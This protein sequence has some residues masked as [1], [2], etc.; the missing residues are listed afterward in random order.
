MSKQVTFIFRCILIAVFVLSGP[1]LAEEADGHDHDHD[2]DHHHDHGHAQAY[3]G[4]TAYYLAEHGD[5]D[6]GF[7]DGQLHLRIHLHAGT[8]VDGEP[9]AKETVF[10]PG[11]LIVVATEEAEIPR[12][13]GELWE[14]TG[15]EPNDAL[16]VLPQIGREHVPAFG[17]ATEEIDPGFFVDD[18]VVLSL[19]YLNGPGDFSL[20]QSDA[21]GIPTFLFSSHANL[22]AAGV[23]VGRHAHYNWAFTAPGDYTLVFEAT[24]QLVAGG[25]VSALSVYTFKVTEGPLCLAPLPGDVNG[26]CVVD[27]Y[28]LEIVQA[29]LGK[30]APRW[31]ADH[32]H[33][34]EHE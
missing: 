23:P 15:A 26:D 16:W 1:S 29:N 30:D 28:D 32:D 20:W 21:F 31:P 7:A 8:I 4:Q 33:P 10:D 13:A 17:L 12:P 24:A 11:Q 27:E 14:P 5:F 22:V 34:H 6:I 2:H 19:R 9:L 18:T 3:E 25:F